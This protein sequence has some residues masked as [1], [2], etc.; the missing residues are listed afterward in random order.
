[1]RAAPRRLGG[2]V[3][4]ICAIRWQREFPANSENISEFSIFSAIL[5]YFGGFSRQFAQSFHGAAMDSLFDRESANLFSRT[6][7]SFSVAA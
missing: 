6:A 5:A 7:K 1:L 4:G 3:A 2:G